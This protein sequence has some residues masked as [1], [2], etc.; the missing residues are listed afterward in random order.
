MIFTQASTIK[1]G[2]ISGA[3]SRYKLSGEPDLLPVAITLASKQ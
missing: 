1:L 2:S 3:L